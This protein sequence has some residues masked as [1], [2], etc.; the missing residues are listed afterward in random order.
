MHDTR[1]PGGESPP[2]TT[3]SVSNGD[4]SNPPVDRLTRRSAA[5]V[6]AAFLAITVA[7]LM[8]IVR[9][10]YAIMEPG[11]ITNTLGNTANGKP[12]LQVSGHGTYPT[13]GGLYF[14]TV[15]V[16]GGPSARPTVWQ[17][18]LG[19]AD[20][21]SAVHQET[22]LFPEGATQKQ[23]EEENTAEMADSQQEAIAV[24]LRAVG[25]DVTE[26]VTIAEVAKGAPSSA[27]LRAGDELVTIRGA[28]ARD[29]KAVRD[30]IGSLP[31][32]SKVPVVLRRDGKTLALQVPTYGS[33]GRTV[34]GV[35]LRTRFDFPFTVKVNAGEVGG[36]SAGLMFT[37]GIYDR[38]TPGAMTGGERI[39]G[40]GTISSD[41]SVG[42]IGGV[43]QKLAGAQVDGADY[44]LAPAGNCD[45]V[46]GHVPEGMDVFT[47]STFQEA[48]TAV[49]AI[50][51][52]HT[53]GLPTCG[54]G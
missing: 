1:S 29:A 25:A 52:H 23:I 53:A 27:L 42:A 30:A 21:D 11:P 14:T 15:R 7:A 4:W 24:A 3:S 26:R 36:P 19:W 16:I 54:T 51:A 33:G 22:Q 45:E 47:V 44:F 31:A 34:L 35:L 37:L 9:V 2:I 5:V 20:P 8:G 48:K 43:Q 46:V 12:L 49:E 18:L 13:S 10:P 40:T 39:A 32:G 50:A 41:G 38:L 28:P 17:V 6:A